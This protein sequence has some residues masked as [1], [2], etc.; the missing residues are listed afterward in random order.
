[1]HLKSAETLAIEMLAIVALEILH[2]KISVYMVVGD[3]G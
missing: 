2:L 3:P 1:M